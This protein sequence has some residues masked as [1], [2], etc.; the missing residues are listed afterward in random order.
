MSR[1]AITIT[2]TRTIAECAD[3]AISAADL[4]ENALC[5][6]VDESEFDEIDVYDTEIES[7]EVVET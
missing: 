5:D 6:I 3:V 4:W 7:I 2:R 1:V